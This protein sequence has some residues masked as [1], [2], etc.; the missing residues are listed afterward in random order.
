VI[1]FDYETLRVIWWVLLGVLLIGFA[2][3]DGFDLGA[4]ILL[5]FVGRNDSERRQVLNSIGPVWEGNQVWLI[6]GGGAIFAAWPL[7]YAA[8]FSGFY[9]AMLLALSAL[10]LR[11][12]S[13][14]YRSKMPGARWRASWDF[15]FFISGLVPALVFGVAVGNALEGAPFRLDD[16]LRMTYEGS[17][18]GL[19]SPF[20]LL[21]GLTSVAMMA[22]QGGA[23]LAGK[24]EAP[25]A[26][27]ARILAFG[28][29]LLLIVLFAAGGVVVAQHLSGYRIVGA[30]AHDAASNP[31]GKTVAREAG[32]WL[33]NYGAMPW[34]MIAPVL[35]FLGAGLAALSLSL[36]RDRLA[37]LASSLS[38]IGVVATVG[39]S[40]FPFVLPSSLDPAS[41]LTVWDASSSRATLFNMLVASALLLPAILVYTAIIYRVLRGKVTASDIDADHASY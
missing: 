37:F 4:G 28:A 3:M 22:M 11:P 2:V 30:L 10:I 19:F 8:A 31:L 23:Y 20:A 6:L 15:L 9:L 21:T 41:S 5:P 1:L 34:T 13:I 32:A 17:F 38:V 12:V 24:T 40:M 7:I 18:F 29:A 26:V 36:G 25:V 33:A 16:T 39:L 14:V 27:R 35:G